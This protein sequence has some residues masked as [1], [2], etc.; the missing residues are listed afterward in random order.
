MKVWCRRCATVFSTSKELK[1]HSAK[2]HDKKCIYCKKRNFKTNLELMKHTMEIHKRKPIQCNYNQRCGNLFKNEIE[3][4]EH[5]SK[6]HESGETKKKCFFCNKMIA[7]MYLHIK[8]NHK[9]EATIK[10]DYY[11]CATYFKSEEERLIHV[12]KIHESGE[13]LKTCI[14]CLRKFNK[15]AYSDHIARIHKS[16]AI[17]CNFGK[18][19]A[20]FFLSTQEKEKHISVVHKAEK[21]LENVSCI[22]CNRK[23]SGNLNLESHITSKHSDVK[24]RCKLYGCFQY[25]F[26]Q[27]EHEKHFVKMHSDKDKLKILKCAFCNY[28][29]AKSTNLREHV[30]H[31][32]GTE[33]IKCPKCPKYCNSKESLKKHWY[34]VHKREAK[35]CVHC[36]FAFKNKIHTKRHFCV[37]CNKLNLCS[38]QRRKHANE[39]KR[40]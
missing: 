8:N 18:G 14:Y 16:E 15:K 22:Y 27:T 35:I 33:N 10:C 11:H 3:L 4:Q 6:F 24:I 13:K 39:C 1:E 5:I 20:T 34:M 21:Y 7:G 30:A 2:F 29:C 31:I 37:F 23:F 9:S 26:T 25:F 38:G 17:K 12:K 36:N 32:H 40:K 28:K 19:C